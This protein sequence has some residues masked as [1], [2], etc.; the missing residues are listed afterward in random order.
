MPETFILN[1]NPKWDEDIQDC[2]SPDYGFNRDRPGTRIVAKPAGGRPWSRETS[3][4]GHTFSLS[5]LNRGWLCAQRLK[6]FY[7]QYEDGFFTIIDWDGGGRHYVGR[8]TGGRFP[9]TQKNNDTYDIQ[10]MT[11]EEMPAVPMLQ[12]PSDW[13][14]DAI[15][16]QPV[17][18]FGDL[19]LFLSGT[20]TQQNQQDVNEIPRVTLFNDGTNPGDFATLEYRGYGFRL[21]MVNSPDAGQIEVFLDTVSLGVVD[22]YNAILQGPQCVLEKADVMLD[23]HRLKVVVLAGKNSASTARSTVWCKLEVMR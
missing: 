14:N 15:T 12:Y 8:F 22:L 16:L 21:W 2:L 3:N 18:D 5:W 23:L 17:D 1:A 11:F 10:G 20:W 13:D 7:E 9:I 19:R 6:Q 4:S